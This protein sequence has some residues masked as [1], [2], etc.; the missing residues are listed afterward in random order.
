VRRFKFFRGVQFTPDN[1]RGERT[2]I[3]AIR[4]EEYLHNIEVR[5]T[6]VDLA[7]TAREIQ[8]RALHRGRRPRNI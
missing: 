6:M 3:D 5:E 7:R 1:Y 8:E 2:I 4:H